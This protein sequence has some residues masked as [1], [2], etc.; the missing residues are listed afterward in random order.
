[1]ISMKVRSSKEQ[2]RQQ[3]R[4]EME[5][6]L[7]GGGRIQ[8]IPN[9]ASGRDPATSGA[10]RP[11]SFAAGPPTTRTDLSAL[12]VA[13]DARKRKAA[14]TPGRRPRRRRKLIYDDFGEPLRWVWDD[15]P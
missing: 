11:P 3:M 14:P 7:A 10:R 5:R 2:Q 15:T 9:G 1:A 8:H 13:I 4:R 6:Y 12:A